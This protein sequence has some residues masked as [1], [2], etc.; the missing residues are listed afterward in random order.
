[1]LTTRPCG[2]ICGRHVGAGR[3]SPVCC[4][5]KMPPPGRAGCFTR[6]RCRRFCCSMEVR[7]GVC[8]RRAKSV[9]KG[10]ISAQHGGCPAFGQ[11]RNPMNL[12]R[13]RARRM[14]WR[15]VAYIQSPIT[16]TFVG[17]LWQILLSIDRSSSSGCTRAVRKR[18]SPVRPFWW[19]QP[20]DLELAP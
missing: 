9:L 7:R 16:W 15:D 20:M 5:L 17:K 1:M 18:G 12:G 11:R 8:L 4:G 13:T 19:D 2:V 3:G 10:F 6:Q 14:C